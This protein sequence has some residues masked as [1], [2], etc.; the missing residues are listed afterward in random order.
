MDRFPPSNSSKRQNAAGSALKGIALLDEWFNNIPS[1]HAPT[2]VH[3]SPMA[4]HTAVP[5]P[6]TPPTSLSPAHAPASASSA[7]GTPSR[8]LPPPPR[9]ADPNTARRFVTLTDQ[10]LNPSILVNARDFQ[11][12]ANRAAFAASLASPPPVSSS[13]S[14]SSLISGVSTRCDTH[15]ASFAL[16]T[17]SYASITTSP[18]ASL[19]SVSTSATVITSSTNANLCRRSPSPSRTPPRHVISPSAAAMSAAVA[20]SPPQA[21]SHSHTAV[22]VTAALAASPSRVA[23][24]RPAAPAPFESETTAH[25]L[26]ALAASCP[27]TAE[28]E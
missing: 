25:V 15:E 11:T 20:I 3:Q 22:T 24:T 1:N 16:S 18:S 19:S 7:P 12:T 27:V 21:Q 17:N 13:L 8:L 6:G 28:A 2:V 4:A 23:S 10:G 5:H 26:R 14:P 9:Y